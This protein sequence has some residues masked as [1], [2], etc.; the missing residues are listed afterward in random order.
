MHKG[1]SICEVLKVNFNPDIQNVF[2]SCT[3]YSLF[4]SSCKTPLSRYKPLHFSRTS[5]RGCR[6]L[7][8]KLPQTLT[9]SFAIFI[10]FS[11][12]TFVFLVSVFLLNWMLTHETELFRDLEKYKKFRTIKDNMAV[13]QAELKQHMSKWP[14]LR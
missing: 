4:Q 5:R 13:F 3:G 14:L 12:L 10:S 1:H 11:I 7:W 2:S 9:N 8:L 6:L